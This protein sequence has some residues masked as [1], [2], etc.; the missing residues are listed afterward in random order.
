MIKSIVE[1]PSTAFFD[2]L[3]VKI[4]SLHYA[5]RAN[6]DFCKFWQQENEAGEV[7]AVIC[8][9]YSAITVCGNKFTN[10]EELISFFNT[11]GYS[12]VLSNI[13]LFNNEE[14]YNSVYFIADGMGNIS[15]DIDYSIAKQ[16]YDIL[17]Q[18]PNEIYIGEFNDWYV[19]ISHRI[20]HS[21]AFII[22]KKFATVVCLKTQNMILINGIA[23]DKQHLNLNLGKQLLNELTK[24][25]NGNLFAVC[26]DYNL[27]FYLKAGFNKH[28]N[29]YYYKG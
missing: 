25:I 14:K 23:V 7:T 3:F 17:N 27:G 1:L 10:T 15:Y 12:E 6:F 24:M 26:S 16:S 11:I 19:D 2:A 20:R 22:N 21:A 28:K 8:K 29:I 9:F 18:Y 13:S 5:Y 4:S